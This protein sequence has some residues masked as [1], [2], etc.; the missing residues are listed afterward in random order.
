MKRYRILVAAVILLYVVLAVLQSSRRAPFFDEAVLAS[1]A[2]NLITAGHMGT[3]V[4][5]ETSA[6]R[7]GMSLKGINS[8]TYQVLPGHFLTQAA[9]YTVFGFGL[10]QM[11]LLSVFWGIIALLA[12]LVI[13]ETLSNRPVALITMTLLAIDAMFLAA[14]SFGRA[15]MATAALGFAALAVYLR[16]RD[17]NLVAAVSISHVL[18]ATAIFTHPTGLLLAISLVM[19]TLVYDR[20]SINA[21]HVVVAA[22]PY[23]LWASGWG[24]YILQ[25]PATFAEQFGSNARGRFQWSAP[26]SLVVSELTGRYLPA[27]GFAPGGSRFSQIKLVLLIAYAVALAGT[28]SIRAIRGQPGYRVLLGLTAIQVLGM[29]FLEGT[30]QSW[31]LIH[32]IPPLTAVLAVWIYW[33]WSTGGITRTITAL[34]VCGLVGLQL[35]RV[36]NVIVADAYHKEYLPVTRFVEADAREGKLVMADTT[37]AFRLGYRN[38]LVDDLR[39]GLRSGKRADTIV[40][41]ERYNEWFDIIRHRE[42]ETA[43]YVSALLHDQYHAV[44]EAGPFKVYRHN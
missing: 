18:A 9:W 29:V 13:L 23:L 33:C 30:R 16:M 35:S 10:F 25:D 40:V 5:D 3:S 7:E 20:R 21:K 24:L 1:P 42:P 32:T 36:V 38:N 37:L 6:W 26:W 44:Y 31:Y 17:R 41:N 27:F 19:T 4:L 8:R 14:A 15:D 2:L 22:L 11:R 43:Q 39:L 12:W 34:C 28:L